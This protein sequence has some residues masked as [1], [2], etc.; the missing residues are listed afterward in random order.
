[1]R[2]TRKGNRLVLQWAERRRS[3]VNYVAWAKSWPWLSRRLNGT[4]QVGVK[5]V[6]PCGARMSGPMRHRQRS[7]RCEAIRCRINGSGW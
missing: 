3:G 6:A 5:M 7:V 4:G 1:M 2:S